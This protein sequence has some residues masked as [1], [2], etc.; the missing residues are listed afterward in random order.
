MRSLRSRLFRT[1]V[2][3][4]V[5]VWLLLAF[6]SYW[7]V[8]V[9][10]DE[11]Y[12]Q[13]LKELA[14]P[15]LSLSTPDIRANVPRPRDADIGTD[16]RDEL[17]VVVWNRSG[18][19]QFRSENAPGLDFA[20]RLKTGASRMQRLHGHPVRWLV[21]WYDQPNRARWIAVLR[22]TT[23]R[24][25]LAV[26]LGIG[27]A[28]P[29]LLAVILMLPLGSWAVRR[30]LQPLQEVGRQVARRRSMDLSRIDAALVP[31]E[32]VPLVEEI[33]GLLHRLDKA[34]DAEKRFT[35][36][37]S[38]EL[39]TPL[40][41]ARA[42]IEVAMGS[43]DDAERQLALSQA[44]SGLSLASDLTEQLLLLARLDHQIATEERV[45]P[46]R[47]A[48]EWARPLDLGELLREQA[49]SHGVQALSKG[50]DLSLELPPQTCV[51][52]GQPVWLGVA[53]GNVLSNAVKFTPAPG[54]VEVQLVCLSPDMAE[55]QVHDSGPGLPPGRMA[56]LGERFFRARH[57]QPGAGLGLSIVSRIMALH[58]GELR[59]ESHDGLQVSLRLPLA[60][61]SSAPPPA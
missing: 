28:S 52:H 11:I 56:L 29:S 35:A 36:D 24:D 60:T 21:H 2:T 54:R 51:V 50:L 12:E 31:N 59:F 48:P 15:L 49:A 13:Q 37:A 38:H 6:G 41:A 3:V 47:R 4:L 18:D 39:R 22:P 34:L 27:L 16:D 20:D 1:L 30:G 45:S 58:G 17:A 10:V 55:I 14:L 7:S 9:E 26:A 61:V 23:E 57:D 42:Q 33:N 32:V 19:V 40:A 8:M 5:P 43:H 53:V 44:L 46:A 25:E